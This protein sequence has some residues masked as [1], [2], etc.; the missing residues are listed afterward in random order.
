VVGLFF[1]MVAVSFLT[2]IGL[3][4]IGVEYFILLGIKLQTLKTIGVQ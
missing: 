4:L 3:Y 2:S 1:E